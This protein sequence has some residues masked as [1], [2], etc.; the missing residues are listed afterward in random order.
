MSPYDY[1]LNTDCS[2]LKAA[3]VIQSLTYISDHCLALIKTQRHF[4]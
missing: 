1:L 4:A 3:P 2:F